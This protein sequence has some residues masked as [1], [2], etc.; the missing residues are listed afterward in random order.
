MGFLGFGKR[1]KQTHGQKLEAA[2]N[3]YNTEM[4][5]LIYPGGKSQAS[6]IVKSLSRIFHINLEISDARM[7]F[8]ILSTYSDVLT[9]LVILRTP[10]DQIIASLLINHGNL[11][12]NKI[13]ARLAF[14]Y[15]E[16]N[17][18]IN[19]FSIET[20]SD[21]QIVELLS[22]IHKDEL[23]T[24]VNHSEIDS[25]DNP[26]YGLTEHEP[27]FTQGIAGSNKYLSALK[28]LS[29]ESLS[30][31]RVGSKSVPGIKGFIDIYRGLLP[32][33]VEYEILYL[34]M[35]GTANSKRIP[36]GFIT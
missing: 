15:C 6:I 11:V 17:I 28:T 21:M 3:C 9:R 35:Y 34:N 4:V 36:K 24:V 18:K 8:D 29:G 26:E 31:D 16:Q 30:W 12:K 27:I 1:K 20:E 13:V 22:S 25:G 5:S 7:Y 19:N 2:Y 32:S 33:G 10:Q 23:K 14:T